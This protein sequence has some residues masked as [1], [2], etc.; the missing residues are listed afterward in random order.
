VR[1]C[2]CVPVCVCVFLSGCLFVYMWVCF[3][4]VG[5]CQLRPNDAVRCAGRLML[6]VNG[7]QGC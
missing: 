2:V 3:I 5:G 4:C 6:G 7:R 1:V